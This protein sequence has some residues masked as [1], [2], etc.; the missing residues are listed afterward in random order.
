MDRGDLRQ[1]H[2]VRAG[3]CGKCLRPFQKASSRRLSWNRRRAGNLQAHCGALRGTHLG[4]ER[5]GPG[6][7]VL[8]HGSRW[9][10]RG[11]FLLT[12]T[13]KWVILIRLEENNP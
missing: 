2:R 5:A 3:V 7:D 10:L 11:R 13:Q 1:W 6:V 12:T 9:R 4:E 8:L